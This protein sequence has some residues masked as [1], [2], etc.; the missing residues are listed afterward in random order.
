MP[1]TRP[2]GRPLFLFVLYTYTAGLVLAC[3]LWRGISTYS[4]ATVPQLV[5]GTAYRPFV[6][7]ALLPSVVRTIVRATPGLE[8]RV[9]DRVTR[10]VEGAH[11]GQR[12]DRLL[13]ALGWTA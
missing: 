12:T 9:T 5:D 4:W 10:A 13:A 3:L 1:P 11:P 8:R 2:R 7:R 6:T